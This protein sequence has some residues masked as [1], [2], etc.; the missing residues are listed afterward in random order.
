M[1]WQLQLFM[2]VPLL[3]LAVRVLLSR[4]PRWK[5]VAAAVF[6]LAALAA[7]PVLQS[8]IEARDPWSAGFNTLQ[9]MHIFA[10]YGA[11]LCLLLWSFGTRDPLWQRIVSASDGLFGLGPAIITLIGSAP[12]M[13]ASAQK[14]AN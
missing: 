11:G 4:D 12:A 3:V 2:V 7:Q 13:F 6:I 10:F 8:M 1:P 5:R 14:G 9:I